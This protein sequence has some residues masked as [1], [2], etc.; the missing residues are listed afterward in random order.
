MTFIFSFA[1]EIQNRILN[2]RVASLKIDDELIENIYGVFN[3][4]LNALRIKKIA[5]RYEEEFVAIVNSFVFNNFF[6]VE[7]IVESIIRIGIKQSVCIIFYLHYKL[8]YSSSNNLINDFLKKNCYYSLCSAFGCYWLANKYKLNEGV[9]KVFILSLLRD[10]GSL[11][12]LKV[13]QEIIEENLYLNISGDFIE[14]II[15]NNHE[16]FGYYYVKN[17]GLPDSIC[18]IVRNHHTSNSK[19]LNYILKYIKIIDVFF[20]CEERYSYGSK[21]FNLDVARELMCLGMP[22]KDINE[23]KKY[24]DNLRTYLKNQN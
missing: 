6:K 15:L 10:I 12:I 3:D 22:I 13:I 7:N 8:K 9:E 1:D 23:L 5:F 2:N 4:N 14:K 20:D 19:D 21:Y 18:N 16:E 24:M 11:V 17:I